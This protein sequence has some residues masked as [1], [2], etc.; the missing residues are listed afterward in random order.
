MLAVEIDGDIH[1]Y[2]KEYYNFRDEFM[3]SIGITTLRFSSDEVFSN[4][5][6]VVNQ[7]EYVLLKQP[8]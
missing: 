5:E 1:K 4:I 7:I 8:I 3:E 6:Y 2:R